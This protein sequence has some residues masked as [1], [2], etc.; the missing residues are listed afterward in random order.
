MSENETTRDYPPIA[1]MDTALRFWQA[2]AARLRAALVEVDDVLT[3]G[4]VE[5]VARHEVITKR[6][7]EAVTA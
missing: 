3:A 4:V 7:R 1:M 2:E 5:T 6:V